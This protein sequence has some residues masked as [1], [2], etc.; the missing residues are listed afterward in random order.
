MRP[1]DRKGA[2]ITAGLNAGTTMAAQS[3]VDTVLPQVPRPLATTIEDLTG[4][5]PGHRDLAEEDV[6]EEA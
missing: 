5:S 3:Y 4:L 2:M 6:A 1:P